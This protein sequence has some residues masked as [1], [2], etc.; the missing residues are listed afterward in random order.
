MLSG[1]VATKGRPTAPA[2][3]DRARK[4]APALTVPL[5]SSPRSAVGFKGA[6][7]G[8][9]VLPRAIDAFCAD[10]HTPTRS[11]AVVLLRDHVGVV[12]TRPAGLSRATAC[13]VVEEDAGLRDPKVAGVLRHPDRHVRRNDDEL[14]FASDG[15]PPITLYL[16]ST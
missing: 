8:L 4:E 5:S 10:P 11:Q 1:A 2:G 3:D 13:P 15:L 16:D 12:G 14:E 7:I 9:G 6:V